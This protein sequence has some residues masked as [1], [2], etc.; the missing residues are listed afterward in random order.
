MLLSKG[1][2][3]EFKI[4]WNAVPLFEIVKDTRKVTNLC[5]KS[6]NEKIKVVI[7]DYRIDKKA[8]DITKW[9]I[10]IGDIGDTAVI[11]DEKGRPVFQIVTKTNIDNSCSHRL[12]VLQYDGKKGWKVYVEGNFVE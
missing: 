6:C 10:H 8:S 2:S 4:Y 5:I 1:E 12:V 11:K 9:S 3:G 7:A